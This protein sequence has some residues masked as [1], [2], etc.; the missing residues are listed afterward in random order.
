MVTARPSL[1]GVLSCAVVMLA[2]KINR[3]AANSHFV[4]SIMQ[5]PSVFSEL[6]IVLR[7]WHSPL[8]TLQHLNLF[9]LKTPQPPIK[10]GAKKAHLAHYKG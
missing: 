3:A 2:P 8:Q 7:C 4:R 9:H 1:V 6:V 5:S 10:W